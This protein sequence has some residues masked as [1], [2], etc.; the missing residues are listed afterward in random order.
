MTDFNSINPY[1]K[2]I[3]GSYKEHSI[4]EVQQKL[5]KADNSFQKWKKV[6]VEKRS[7]LISNAAI[8]LRKNSENYAR[9]ITVEMGKP[10]IE[11]RGEIEKCAWVCDYYAQNASLFLKDEIIQSDAQKSFVRHNPMGCVFAVM[12]WNYPFWQVF[13]YAAPVLTAGNTTI[14]KHASNVFGCALLIEEVFKEAG[15]PEDIF[16]NIF[17]QHDKVENVVSNRAIKAITLTGS[18]RAGA[19]V[20]SLAGK[21]LKKSLMELG[22]NN[23]FVVFKDANIDEAVNLAITARMRNAGQSCIAAKRFI[24]QK[25][26][27]DEF[28]SKFIHTVQLLKPGNPLDESTE[29]GPLARKEF[30]VSLHSQ[31][32][33]SVKMGADLLCGGNYQDAFFE[34]TVLG[35]VLPSMPVFEE[36]TFG[37]VAAMIKANDEIE[38]IELASK[39]KYGLGTTLCTTKIDRAI[40]LT[41]NINDG[42]FFINELVKSDPRLPFGGTKN[43]GYG[44]E[45]SKDGMMEF[46]NRKTVFVK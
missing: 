43:S 44:R 26:V 6:S 30:A 7:A 11:S 35:N 46:V 34:Q 21:Y 9:M 18:E 13:R 25:D 17:I 29:I 27:Y 14:L 39:S 12:P 36:E 31:I 40:D 1:N 41:D 15:F 3:V 10:I 38:A 32:K 37:P 20:A 22:G 24:I 4:D 28:V 8:V 16:Q 5:S 45:L 42:A 33:D 19:A 2:V 23:A